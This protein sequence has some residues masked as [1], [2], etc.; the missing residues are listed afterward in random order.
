LYRTL[1]PLIRRRQRAQAIDDAAVLARYPPRKSCQIQ[2]L[3]A[4]LFMQVL[5]L[6]QVAR[7]LKLGTISL[8][9]TKIHADASKSKAVSDKHLLAL[10][11]H[12]CAEVEELFALSERVDQDQDNFTDPESRIMKHSLA[13]A[14]RYRPRRVSGLTILSFRYI[15]VMTS[16]NTITRIWLC[17][18]P[19]ERPAKR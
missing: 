8:D 1:R 19:H 16:D 10:E 12:L 9:G 13:E 14:I 15:V 3:A 11:A 7:V 18:D 2:V 17:F 6:A 5:L 4:I